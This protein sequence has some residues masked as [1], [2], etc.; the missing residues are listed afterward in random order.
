LRRLAANRLPILAIP[1]M[2]PPGRLK[3]ATKPGVPDEEY[4]WDPLRCG[5]GSDDR[6]VGTCPDHGYAAAHLAGGE[7]RHQSSAPISGTA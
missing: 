5:L 1:V 6:G 4:N 2:L 7:R 3:L